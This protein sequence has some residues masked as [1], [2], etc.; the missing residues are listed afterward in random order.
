MHVT[1]ALD[2][3]NVELVASLY[4]KIYFN[5]HADMAGLAKANY[6]RTHLFRT[7]HMQPFYNISEGYYSYVCTTYVAT[8]AR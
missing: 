5:I 3:F 2:A 7:T 8:L 4:R 1:Q 6:I